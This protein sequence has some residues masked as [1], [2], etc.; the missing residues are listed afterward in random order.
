MTQINFIPID[1]DYFD[2]NSKT[3]AKITGRTED[4]KKTVI[5]DNCDVYFWAILHDGLKDKKIEEIRKEIEKAKKVILIENNAT[6]QLGRIL[7]EKT[8]IKIENRILKYD[9]KPFYSDELTEE[10]LAVK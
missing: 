9:G 4:N 3:Y 1:Y 10:I 8:G 6:G 2:F 7:R 5:I